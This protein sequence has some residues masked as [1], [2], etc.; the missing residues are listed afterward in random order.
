MTTY[1]GYELYC[2]MGAVDFSDWEGS[3]IT[4]DENG[5]IMNEVTNPLTW[6]SFS[7][8]LST[9]RGLSRNR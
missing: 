7:T 2:E 9:I 1:S 5:N 3:I 8:A 6:R 4:F